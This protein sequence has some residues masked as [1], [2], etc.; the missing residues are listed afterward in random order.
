MRELI[1]GMLMQQKMTVYEMRLQIQSR[2]RDFCT[3]SLGSIQAA[4]KRLLDENK[5]TVYEYVEKSVNKKRYSITDEGR[6]TFYEWAKSPIIITDVKNTEFGKL[7][8][9]GMLPTEQRLIAIDET[10]NW[11]KEELD[12]VGVVKVEADIVCNNEAQQTFENWKEDNDYF[13]DVVDKVEDIS[14]YKQMTVQYGIE[15]I[16]FNIA[17]FERLKKI[18]TKIYEGN[19]R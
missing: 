1:L 15:L 18:N 19:L 8:F 9:L 6:K 7:L 14:L 10:L 3:D 5:V 13:D 4:V 16:K 12:S 2:Y 11:L 17:W